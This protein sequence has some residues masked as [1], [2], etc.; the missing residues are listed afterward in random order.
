MSVSDA[1]GKYTTLLS[2]CDLNEKVNFSMKLR[3]GMSRKQASLP[4][5]LNN[6]HAVGLMHAQKN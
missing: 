4:L 5:K 3:R 6:K 1:F 2:C